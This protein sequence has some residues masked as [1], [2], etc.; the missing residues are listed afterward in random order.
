MIAID[1]GGTFTD[2]V[3]LRGGRIETAKISTDYD[4]VTKPI[5]AGARELNVAD[6]RAFNHA[7]THGLNA[8]IT[9]R[10]PKIGFLNTEGHRDILD[11]GRVWRPASAILD[12]RW[13]RSFGD[14][15]RP[16]VPRYLRRGIRE[17]ILADGSVLFPLDEAQ[18][19]E[20]LE[21]LKRCGVTGVSICLLNSYVN[22]A[23]EIRL[24]AL[25]CEVLGDV[26]CSISSEVSP[27]AREYPRASAAGIAADLGIGT[28]TV[29]TH[30]KRL[31]ERLS[32]GSHTNCC[33]G[34]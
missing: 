11:M 29:V 1:A 30:R 18:A 8:V 2:V 20:E 17:R 33:S 22:S 32:I 7:S 24:N 4:D 13:R 26:A 21:V 5:L 19:R 34:I 3:S 14:A 28:E 16:L 9:R 27:L 10:L 31:Y 15:T 25:V 12:P 6:A 23:H